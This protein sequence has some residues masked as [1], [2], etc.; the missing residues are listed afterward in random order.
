MG[1]VRFRE[2]LNE[3]GL[4]GSKALLQFH[5]DAR[6]YSGLVDEVQVSIA[7]TSILHDLD[8]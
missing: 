2:W 4:P 3:E 5:Q 8:A 1:L 7:S 6:A